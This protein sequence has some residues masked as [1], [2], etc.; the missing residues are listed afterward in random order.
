MKS[1]LHSVCWLSLS[2][3]ACGAVLA[4]E[5]STST[6][7]PPAMNETTLRYG[8]SGSMGT[9]PGQRDAVVALLLRDVEEMKAVGC[10]LYVVSVSDDKP[11]TIFITEVWKTADAHK[12]S[13][14]LPSVKA[15]IAEAMPMLSGEFEQ[16]TYSVVGGLGLSE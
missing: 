14:Q 8:I 2:L 3:L 6:E 4:S 16:V 5:P 7:N 11:D 12:A 13:L 15:A 1:F 10:D 9:K